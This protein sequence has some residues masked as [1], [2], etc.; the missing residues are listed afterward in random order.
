MGLFDMDNI[1]GFTWFCR[2]QRC[3]CVSQNAVADSFVVTFD[4]PFFEQ[5][6]PFRLVEHLFGPVNPA[7]A[8]SDGVGGIHQVAHDE[9]TVIE[10]CRVGAVS[11][12][13]QNNG[14]SIKRIV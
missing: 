13:N 11:E 12:D 1:I 14:S 5:G 3:C 8:E 4:P 9:R 2:W 10:I 7:T 6:F